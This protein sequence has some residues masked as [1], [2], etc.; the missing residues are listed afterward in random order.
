MDMT[1]GQKEFV[2]LFDSLTGAYNRHQIWQDM[3]L[4]SATAIANSIQTAHFEAR[5]QTYLNT[6]GKYDEKQ[7]MK[8]AELL[9][10]LIQII[11]DS[12]NAG[13][14]GDFLGELFMMMGLGNDAGGQFFTPYHV[15]QLMA[16]M[17]DIDQIREEI[18]REG[19]IN[20]NEPACGAGA[21]LIAFAERLQ[22]KG[23]NYQETVLFTAQDIDYTT[24][25]MCYIQLSLIGCAGYVRIG[26]TLTDPDTANPMFG[27]DD[28]TVWKTPMYFSEL[29]NVRRLTRARR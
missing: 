2:K 8:F 14:Y 5:E 16:G 11:D 27:G 7:R 9:G 29:W 28:A 17:A 4:M 3:I 26:D 15:C 19:Y 13:H 1:G 10:M 12:V 20:V 18:E 23:I 25:L 6:I 21:T 22:T 24:A